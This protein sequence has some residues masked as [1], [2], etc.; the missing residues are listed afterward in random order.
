MKVLRHGRVALITLLVVML[1]GGSASGL[2]IFWPTVHW[3]MADLSV[4]DSLA[5]QYPELDGKLVAF[6]AGDQI[7]VK[8]L[9]TNT[10]RWVPDTGGTQQWPDVSGDRVVFQDNASGNWDIK[11]YQWSTNTVSTVRATSNNEIKPRI[12]GNYVV[13]YDD[14]TDLLWGRDY[15]MGGYT[16]R[17]HIG[18]TGYEDYDVDNGRLVAYHDADDKIWLKVLRPDTN[19]WTELYDFAEDADTIHMHGDRI[20]VDTW[21]TGDADWNAYVYNIASDVAAPLANDPDVDEDFPSVFHKTVAYRSQA[22][23]EDSN[24]E[25][26]WIDGLYL[27]TTP[28]FGDTVEQDTR[29]SLYGHRIAYMRYNG[30]SEYD[31]MMATSDLKLASRTQGATR[32]STAA[33]V[34]AAYFP[35]A[36]DVVL[37]NGQNFPDALSA[38]PLARALRAPLLLTGPDSLPAETLAEITRIAPSKV[39][40]IGGPDVVST[41][42]LEQ[43]LA[44]Y[45]VERIAGDTRY[46]TSAE[47]ANRLED[48]LGNNV[49][50]RAFF[51]RG[52]MFPDALA[53]GPVA[54]GAL[55][56]ILL[57]QP[58]A[59]PPA[60]ATAVDDLD[61]TLGF[62]LG[63]EDAVSAGVDTQLRALIEANGAI[64]TI[65]ERWGGVDRYETA[66]IAVE[67]GLA[68]PE[69]TGSSRRNNARR[70]WDQAAEACRTTPG[71]VPQYRDDPRYGSDKPL[72]TDQ[73][74]IEEIRKRGFSEPHPLPK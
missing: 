17:Q 50:F 41:D 32:Y 64:G 46:E 38:T 71:C 37:C 15:D 8:N 14:T 48:I 21:N 58:D 67:K 72:K 3:T 35:D 18:P 30:A 23:G 52:D 10:Y 1:L 73:E 65:T 66:V 7:R 19:S 20:V 61:I 2:E 28:A 33:A 13:W 42:I 9:Q 51:A 70:E 63:S 68:V 44:L 57:V 12:D 36:N 62:I 60:V 47:I 11:M 56:P 6:E 43:L 34:S 31:V 25:Y 74:L 53:A 26:D 55:G 16:A 39:W 4:S 24:I 49:V 54:S 59:V 22:S 29:P 27:I 40:I 45:D 5:E 69:R